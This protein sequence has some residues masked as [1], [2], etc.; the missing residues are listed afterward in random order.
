MPTYNERENIAQII[1]AILSMDSRLHVLI[2][3]DESPDG[4]AAAVDDLIAGGCAS[5]LFLL[6]RSAK[7]G[8]GSAYVHGLKWGLE[9]GYTFLIQMDADWSHPPKY[10]ERMLELAQEFD[11]VVGSRYVSGGGTLN[12]GTGRRLLSRFASIYS[13]LILGVDIADFTGGFNGWSESVLHEIDMDSLKSDGYSFQIEMKYRAHQSGSKRTEFPILFNER[14]AGK[15]KMSASIA[16]EACWRVWQLR[17][18]GG[19]RPRP[20]LIRLE[21]RCSHKNRGA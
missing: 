15:S 8:L 4:T 9:K 19:G 2:V 10:L 21:S 13:R 18:L 20:D 17:F 11:C 5:R 6:R 1:P 14:R 7:L 12:W 3:D 16:L